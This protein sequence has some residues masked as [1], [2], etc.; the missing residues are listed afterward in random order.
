MKFLRF[1]TVVLLLPVLL[2]TGCFFS[3]G[4]SKV[5]LIPDKSSTFNKVSTVDETAW[6]EKYGDIS[7]E[8]SSDGYEGTNC[9]YYE[10]EASGSSAYYSPAINLAQYITSE[11]AYTVRFKYKV[12]A[13]ETLSPFYCAI[14]GTADDCN[15]FIKE[16]DGNFYADFAAAPL[17]V[18]GDWQDYELSFFVKA[19]D[20]KSSAVWNFCLHRISD[21][22]TGICIDNFELF[23]DAEDNKPSKVTSA[24]TWMKNEIVLV[25]DCHYDDAFND[26]DVDLILTDGNVTYTVPGFWDGNNVWRIRFVCPTAGKWTYRTVCTNPDDKGLHD[27]AGKIVCKDYDGE[28]DIYKHGFIKTEPGT[29]YFMYDDGTPFFYLGDTH[30]SLGTESEDMVKTIAEC[31]AEQGYTVIQSEPIGA[32]FNFTDGIDEKDISALRIYDRKFQAIADEGLVHANAQF[33]YPSYMT[34]CIENNG[35][36]SENTVSLSEIE[37]DDTMHDLSDQAKT[38]LKKISRYWVARYSAYP[39]MWTLGQEVDNDFY[40]ERGDGSHSEWNYVNNPYKLI[41]EYIDEYDPYDHPLTAHQEATIR[42]TALGNGYGEAEADN[43][44]YGGSSPSAFRHVSAHTWYAAQWSPSLTDQYEYSVAKDYWYN[45]QGKPVV[46]YEGRYCYLWTKDFGAR[47]QGWTAY[48]NGMFGYA[49]G[50]HDTWSY[51]NKYNEDADSSDGVDTITSE[52]KISATWEDS[53]NYP[54]SL[55]TCYM[56]NFF[57]TF[58]WWNLVPRFDDS[59]YFENDLDVY[60]VVASNEDNTEMVIYF[61][62]FYDSSVAENNNTSDYGGVSTGIIGNLEPDT[63]YRYKWFNPITGEFSEE[64]GFVSSDSGTYELGNKIWNGKVC[65]TD[66]VFYLYK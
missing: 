13:D 55:Q 59:D 45:G 36:Y 18:P 35:G 48:L 14:R 20:I 41:A 62:G 3:S 9:L 28:L 6:T 1:A 40:W 7:P 11:G 32:S 54:S 34:A 43:V 17:T 38:Y 24:V 5:N 47:M 2:L 51:G 23:S 42:T 19:E 56:R 61:Y 25:S 63:A 52:E 65:G 57:E 33:F 60:S 27:I 10:K 49:W 64:F 44:F 8:I 31:R 50:G 39:V 22:V 29:R 21:K 37:K 26:V 53:L 66:L 4:N 12:T 15:S 30:W 58:D 16:T 46:N